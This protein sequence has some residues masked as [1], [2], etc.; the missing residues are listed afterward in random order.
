ML[1]DERI[2]EAQQSLQKM[3][4]VEDLAPS[5]MVWNEAPDDGSLRECKNN[6]LP[7]LWG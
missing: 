3:L 4:D 7:R 1:D 2:V 5:R 6:C